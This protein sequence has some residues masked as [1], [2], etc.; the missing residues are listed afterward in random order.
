MKGSNGF[1]EQE[2]LGHEDID[3][4]CNLDGSKTTG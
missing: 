1:G 3:C 2:N 4:C